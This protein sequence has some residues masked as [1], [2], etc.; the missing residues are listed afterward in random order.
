MWS[1][2]TFCAVVL[3]YKCACMFHDAI[4]AMG[5]YVLYCRVW[6]VHTGEMLNTLLHHCEAVLHL[7][8]NSHTMVTCSKVSGQV[9]Y[10]SHTLTSTWTVCVS[11]CM[12]VV[13]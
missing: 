2:S 6:D 12:P 5:M 1:D 13:L 9:Y 11:Q 10:R 3:L 7:R 4:A 8:F